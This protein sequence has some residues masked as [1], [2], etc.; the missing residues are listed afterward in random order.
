MLL[1]RGLNWICRS[2]KGELLFS[3]S[4]SNRER[5]TCA[6]ALLLSLQSAFWAR[7]ADCAFLIQMSS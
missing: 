4:V 3:E 7:A 6:K 2:Q 5:T 1:E